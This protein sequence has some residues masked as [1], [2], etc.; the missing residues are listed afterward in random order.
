MWVATPP[1]GD[2]HTGT[3][4]MGA[5]QGHRVASLLAVEKTP[6]HVFISPD[7]RYAGVVLANGT[8]NVKSDPRYDG[9]LRIIKIFAIGPGTLTPVAETDSCHWAQG[10]TF[11]PDGRLVLLMRRL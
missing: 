1:I 9:L 6:E 11:S 3:V 7:R 2:D 10:A 4:M 5:P 8:A